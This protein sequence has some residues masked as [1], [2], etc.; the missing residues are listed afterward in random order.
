MMVKDLKD[1]LTKPKLC[2]T[3][4]EICL[5]QAQTCL[6][7]ANCCPNSNFRRVVVNQAW[8]L[9][10]FLQLTPTQSWRIIEFMAK[11]LEFFVKILE[12]FVKILSLVFIEYIL[13]LMV[14]KNTLERYVF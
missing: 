6:T 13:L 4:A 2:L 9:A 10:I 5:T 8:F 7:Q 12:F 14:H 11:F 3:Q 1:A